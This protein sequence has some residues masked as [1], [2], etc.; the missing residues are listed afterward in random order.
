MSYTISCDAAVSFG[1]TWTDSRNDS[2]IGGHDSSFDDYVYGLGFQGTNKIGK[3]I[4]MI[5][6]STSGDGNK[7]NVIYRP[8]AGGEWMNGNEFMGTKTIHAY[9]T[10][11]SLTPG[12]YTSIAGKLIVETY[13][14]A[15]ETLD[16]SKTV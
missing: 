10:P 15:T 3:Y 1:T 11:G 13:I 6:P 5:D 12:S 8:K 16:M 2:V 14:A 9:A 4:L 7:V